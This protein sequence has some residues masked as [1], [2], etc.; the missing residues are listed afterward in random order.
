M[1]KMGKIPIGVSIVA[2]YGGDQF[3][4]DA[5]VKLYENIQFEVEVLIL[6]LQ[7][8]VLPLAAILASIVV[9]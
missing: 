2:R 8:Y 7:S 5:L 3:L 9:V 4:L 6:Y 1:G